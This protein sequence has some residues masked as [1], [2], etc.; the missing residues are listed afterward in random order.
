MDVVDQSFEIQGFH[1]V[2]GKGDLIDVDM[3]ITGISFSEEV[4]DK[5]CSLTWHVEFLNWSRDD[6][7]FFLEVFCKGD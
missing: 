5:I 1:H 2:P 4:E 6:D 7:G 3:F